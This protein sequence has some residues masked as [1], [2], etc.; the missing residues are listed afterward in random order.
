MQPPEPPVI[1]AALERLRASQGPFVPKPRLAI[2]DEMIATVLSQHTSDYNSERAF[3]QLKAEFPTWEQVATAEQARVAEA[4]RSGGIASTKARRI[5]QI[6]AAIAEREGR[7]DLTRL[8]D[9][10]DAAVE[11]YLTSLPG[12]GPK[13]AA[14]VLAFSMGRAAFPIDT[15]VHRITARLGWI[16]QGVTA[17]QAY[18][19]LNPAIPPAIRYDLHLAFISHGRTVCK[20]RHPDCQG[21]VLR[22][23]CAYAL[24]GEGARASGGTVP[25][26][27]R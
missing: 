10:D 20:A 18:R 23:M 26:C 9:L 24:H 8:Q 13:T 27:A 17:E 5:Q 7:L 6:L 4:I 3:A 16:H 15:H 21:C 2:I 22:Q 11:E 25:G 14:C 12:V 19:I 1:A